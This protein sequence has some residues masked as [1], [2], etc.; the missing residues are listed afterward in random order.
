MEPPGPI[1]CHVMFP[2]ADDAGDGAVAALLSRLDAAGLAGAVLIGQD[3]A[4]DRLVHALAAAP[5]RLRGVAAATPDLSRAVLE[6]LQGAGVVGIRFDLVGRPLPALADR[7]WRALIDMIGWRGMHLD[8]DAAGDQWTA[9]LPPLRDAGVRVVVDHFGRPQG[10]LDCAG[11]RA[12][13]DAGRAGDIWVKLST[14]ADG[15]SADA[16][17]CAVA[18]LDAFGPNRLVAGGLCA[19]A[20][21]PVGSAFARLDAWI[22]DPAVRSLILAD[23]TAALY[24]FGGPADGGAWTGMV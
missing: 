7:P 15:A 19:P 12:I 21:S 1:D 18:L 5:P 9:I 11:F 23:N 8:I 4:H 24:G 17:A 13:L 14:P 20:G 3:A 16:A 22:A 6:R 2:E 10:G